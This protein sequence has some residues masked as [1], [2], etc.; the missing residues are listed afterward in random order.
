[1]RPDGANTRT[2]SRA[3]AAAQASDKRAE[4][5]DGVKGFVIE[6]QAPASART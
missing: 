3:T 1:M 6:R 4:T 5:A 2:I